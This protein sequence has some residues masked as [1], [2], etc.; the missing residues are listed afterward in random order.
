M[1]QRN[2]PCIAADERTILVAFVDYHRATLLMK[3]DGLDDEQVRR[4]S[5][6]PSTLN[7]LGLVRHMA[8]VERHWFQRVME[9]REAPPI[10]YTDEDE[11]LDMLP[12]P[13]ATLEDAVSTLRGEISIS[14]AV[15]AAH[16]M[17]DLA[18]RER[19]TDSGGTFF[20]NLRWIL[21]HMIEE[22]ARHCGH[23]D[24]LREAVDGVVGD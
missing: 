1:I 21:V 12:P 3:A 6:A 14:D 16:S 22:Y 2:D 9:N 17:D 23:A 13:E 7:L 20:P 5:V 19:R 24:L 10:Y 8:E 18:L 11:D 15:I 4:P